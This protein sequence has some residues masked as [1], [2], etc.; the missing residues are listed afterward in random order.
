MFLERPRRFHPKKGWIEVIAGSMFSGKT[1]EL[2]RRL[3]RAEFA[4][5]QVEIFKPKIDVRYSD[6]DVVSHDSN[7]IK[8]TPV[9]NSA[10]ILLMTSDVEVV[11]ID[12]A[13]FFDDGLVDVCTK[14]ANQ[15]IRVIVAGLD[16]DFMGRPFGPIPKLFALAE[17]VTKV[18]AICMHCG[19]L[20]QYSH[21]KSGGNDVVVLGEKDIYEPL[22]RNCYNEAIKNEK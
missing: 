8:S 5:M 19:D 3:K 12:E 4:R 2:I 1:E 21:R 16:M 11:G 13:Q 15:G 22:C 18:H 7:A 6:D 14:L 17:Y 9:S 10:N 20:A